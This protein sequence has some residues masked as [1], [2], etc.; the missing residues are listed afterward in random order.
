MNKV[1]LVHQYS[2]DSSTVHGVYTTRI[3][4][5]QTLTEIK[6]EYYLKCGYWG[7]G[8]TAFWLQEVP[9]DRRLHD[10]DY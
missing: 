4:A 10:A 2:Y 9:L 1:Y 6:N 5:E 7:Q 3:A 8:G